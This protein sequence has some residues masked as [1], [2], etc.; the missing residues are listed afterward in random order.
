MTCSGGKWDPMEVEG[1]PW[2][3]L[4]TTVAWGREL[5]SRDLRTWDS[6]WVRCAVRRYTPQGCDDRGIGREKG[7]S[8]TT[9]KWTWR[10]GRARVGLGNLGSP[11]KEPRA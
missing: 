10:V 2:L 7:G 6:Q 3:A 11:G 8:E 5:G 4:G 9:P 1:L